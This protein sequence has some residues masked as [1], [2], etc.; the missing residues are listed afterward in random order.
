MRAVLCHTDGPIFATAFYLIADLAEQE[1]RYANAGHPCPLFRDQITGEVG[2]LISGPSEQ[3]S[4]LGLFDRAAYAVS[5]CEL[6]PNDL[7]I[8]YT[9]GLCEATG[10][11]GTT[12][13]NDR[14]FIAV[15]DQ[16]HLPTPELF[17]FLLEDAKAF[18]GRETFEDDVCIVGIQM[19]PCP[20]EQEIADEPSADLRHSKPIDFRDKDAA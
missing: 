6:R 9:D 13:G 18:S 1:I 16:G 8:L 15:R 5:R 20:A 4:A 12:F 7:F 11:D 17:D 10:S 19:L 14:L 3:G 2:L